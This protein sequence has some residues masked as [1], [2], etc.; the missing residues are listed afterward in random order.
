MPVSFFMHKK[1]A[2][3]T[4]GR[5]CFF[6]A[7]QRRHYGDL[8]RFVHEQSIFPNHKNSPHAAKQRCV[9]LRTI[10]FANNYLSVKYSHPKSAVSTSDFSIKALPPAHALRQCSLY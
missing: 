10:C 7:A 5:V 9:G 3:P 8:R 6:N 1:H 4:F 2:P